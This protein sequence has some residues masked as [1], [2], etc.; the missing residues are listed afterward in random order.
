[1]V[2]ELW[3]SC[4]GSGVVTGCDAGSAVLCSVS[5]HMC[6][7]RVEVAFGRPCSFGEGCMSMV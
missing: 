3:W 5:L 7:V 6:R 2:C 1:M 4:A